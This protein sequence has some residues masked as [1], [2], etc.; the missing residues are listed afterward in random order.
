MGSGQD[1]KMTA[2]ERQQEA[3]RLRAQGK[4]YD[5]IA[6]ALGYASRAG[7]FKSVKSAMQRCQHEGVVEMRTLEL[8]RLDAL[9]EG[10]WSNATSGDPKAI[11]AALRIAERRASLLGLDAPSRLEISRLLESSGWARVRSAVTSA[12]EP[13]PEAARAVAAALTEVQ[14]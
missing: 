12:L 8:A 3:L 1:K 10:V 9:L 4:N 7:A 14:E 11:N 5:D 2:F 13:W 6:A